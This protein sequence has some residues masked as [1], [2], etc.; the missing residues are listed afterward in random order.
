MSA[1]CMRSLPPRKRT[2]TSRSTPSALSLVP[3]TPPLPDMDLIQTMTRS[4]YASCSVWEKRDK[5][6]R[7]F[8]RAL[9]RY[10]RSWESRSRLIRRR[11]RFKMLREASTRP[12]TIR[13]SCVQDQKLV[14]T[15]TFIHDAPLSTR[16]LTGGAN[17][18][19]MQE[20][21]RP[22]AHPS[23]TIQETTSYIPD[24]GLLPELLLDHQNG[25]ANVL[26]QLSMPLGRYEAG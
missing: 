1:F 16:L 9:N 3:T 21:D 20:H 19:K 25:P 7:R 13:L 8:T 6:E 4:I 17:P 22:P 2:R 12:L 23:R 26:C 10:L 5:L 15:R 24:I 14:A 18:W 11:T